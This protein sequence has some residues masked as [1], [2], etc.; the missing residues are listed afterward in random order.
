MLEQKQ[1]EQFSQDFLPT[2]PTE[3]TDRRTRLVDGNATPLLACRD[4]DSWD[5]RS[6]YKLSS[7][8]EHVLEAM[9]P[10]TSLPNLVKIQEV[11]L[12]YL[13]VHQEMKNAVDTR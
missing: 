10:F 8:I 9:L 7:W 13:K 1:A 11:L 6:E 12:Q 4:C 2:L 5:E 3:I